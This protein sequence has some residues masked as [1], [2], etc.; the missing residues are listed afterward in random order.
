MAAERKFEPK[1]V[2]QVR[3]L[4]IAGM[5]DDQIAGVFEVAISTLNRWKEK[6]PEFMAAMKEGKDIADAEIVN[7]LY[8]R[9]KGFRHIAFKIMQF[10]GK[11]VTKRYV[12]HFPPDTTACIFWLKNRQPELWRDVNRF[13]HT[14]KDGAPIQTEEVTD[15]EAAR[16]VAFAMATG[17]DAVTKA[18]KSG[19]AAA[20]KG[21]PA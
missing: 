1:M 10:E 5:T 2:R 3:K 17:A 9:A 15:V 18:A 19:N 4:A 13:E 14:G 11:A 7:A 16:I 20:K 6:Y 8:H 12:E 21:V